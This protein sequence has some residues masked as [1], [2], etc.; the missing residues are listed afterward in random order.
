MKKIHRLRMLN[1]I[2]RENE[3]LI[4][5]GSGAFRDPCNE[6]TDHHAKAELKGEI[7]PGRLEK[8]T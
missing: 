5:V 2:L 1:Q 4:F 6:N 3:H 7:G 8:A